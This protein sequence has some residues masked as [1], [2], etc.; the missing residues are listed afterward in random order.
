M[1]LI[2]TLTL[3]K[4]ISDAIIRIFVKTISM[5]TAEIIKEIQ[6]LPVTQRIYVVEKTIHS[7]R[8]Q[9]EKTQMAKAADT[10]KDD[11][12]TDRELTMFT[13]LDYE[14]FYETR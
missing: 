9:E 2:L 1:K 4:M 11:Y 8:K 12:E 6:N 14:N 5:K 7:I 10:L 3:A 13:N